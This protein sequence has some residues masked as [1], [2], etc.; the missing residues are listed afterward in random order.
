[1]ASSTTECKTIIGASTSCCA[2]TGEPCMT[3]S[4]VITQ[5]EC[6]QKCEKEKLKLATYTEH[7]ICG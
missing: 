7:G 1:M 6:E 5:K 3:T 4:G 2:C